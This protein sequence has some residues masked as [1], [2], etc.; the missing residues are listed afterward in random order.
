MG[1]DMECPEC[2]SNKTNCCAVGEGESV[3][4]VPKEMIDQSETID[5]L[6]T[7]LTKAQE[8]VKRGKTFAAGYQYELA[9]SQLEVVEYR[10]RYGCSEADLAK[11][12]E[13]VERLKDTRLTLSR[14]LEECTDSFNKTVERAETDE[15]RVKELE[16]ELSNKSHIAT[17]L[18]TRAKG[19]DR[20]KEALESIASNDMRSHFNRVDAMTLSQWAREALQ[21]DTDKGKP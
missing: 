12:Q 16:E 6:R 5:Q 7:E 15:A 14:D 8:E 4:I 9:Q 19:H 18:H 1:S 21:V 3:W 2:G 20:F 10:E 11:R 17:R 13:E